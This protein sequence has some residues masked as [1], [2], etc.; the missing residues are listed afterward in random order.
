MLLY[1]RIRLFEPDRMKKKNTMNAQSDQSLRFA[2]S[3]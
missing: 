2:L 3:G 1:T